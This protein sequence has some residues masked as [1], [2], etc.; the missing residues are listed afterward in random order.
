M[1]AAALL[2]LSLT[3][4]VAATQEAAA[5]PPLTSDQASNVD[6]QKDA[7]LCRSLSVAVN[8]LELTRLGYLDK[9][10][11][12]NSL[13][14]VLG[15]VEKDFDL[16]KVLHPAASLLSEVATLKARVSDAVASPEDPDF[17]DASPYGQQ[18]AVI[19]QRCDAEG[20]PLSLMP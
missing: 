10:I 19:G 14:F 16:L 15:T 11:D 5:T 2:A 8:T 6:N 9:E 18:L 1:V 3:G 12:R 4:C 7:G 17:S 20:A 13:N